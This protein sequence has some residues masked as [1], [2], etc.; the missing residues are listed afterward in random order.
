MEIFHVLNRGVEKRHIILDDSDRL[1]FLHDLYAFNDESPTPNYILSGRHEPYNRKVL[2]HIHAYCLMHNHYHLLLSEAAENGISLFLK[3][4]NGGYAKYFNER[5]T[6]AGA[7]WQ[8]KTKK[9]LARRDAHFLYLPF[10]IHLNPLDFKYPE[11]RNGR[12]HNVK[13]ALEYLNGYRWSSYL[14]YTGTRNFPSIIHTELLAS[15]LGSKKSQEKE[16]RSIIRDRKLAQDSL[17]LELEKN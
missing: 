1:R 14:D 16:V 17:A 5:Y 15:M 9:I 13:K 6:R 10:Y 4:L 3:K 7:L 11:W 12:V 8:G 2:V